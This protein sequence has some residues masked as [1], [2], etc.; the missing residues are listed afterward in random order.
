MG[1][2]VAARVCVVAVRLRATVWLHGPRT[3][4]LLGLAAVWWR[5][6]RNGCVDIRLA[7]RTAPS[8]QQAAQKA[9]QD[10]SCH[11][12]VHLFSFSL[13]TGYSQ[14]P[15]LHRPVAHG[16]AAEQGVQF[17]FPVASRS[18]LQLQGDGSV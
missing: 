10:C 3:V 15:W 5:G 12:P 13:V 8:Q 2:F 18:K 7:A 16:A 6:L 9:C 4:Q 1:I 14:Y 17:V 11:L